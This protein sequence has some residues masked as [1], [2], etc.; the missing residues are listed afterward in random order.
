ME[1]PRWYYPV[2]QSLGAVLVKAGELDKA[3]QAFRSSLAKAPN[4][5]WALYGLA[6]VYKQRGDK[7]GEDA[8][9]KLFRN[10]WA[11]QG[12]TLDL[13]KL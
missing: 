7:T 8:T 2:R 5:A 13:A 1:P 12:E 11:G 3:E 4:N 9:R 10:A 6:E